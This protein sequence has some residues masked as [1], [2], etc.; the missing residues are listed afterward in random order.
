MPTSKVERPG[1]AA[2]TGL[3]TS[4]AISLGN[5]LKAILLPGKKGIKPGCPG[6]FLPNLCCYVL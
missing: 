5:G 6:W 2:S 4:G 3:Y 1:K